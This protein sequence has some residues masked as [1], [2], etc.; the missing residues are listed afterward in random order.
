MVVCQMLRIGGAYQRYPNG[1]DDKAMKSAPDR[2]SP[3]EHRCLPS[4]TISGL[5]TGSYDRPAFAKSRYLISRT[6]EL[7]GPRPA[8]T[9]TSEAA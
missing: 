7:F 4:R 5:S 1:Q 9:G 2:S 3:P 6:L 8:G